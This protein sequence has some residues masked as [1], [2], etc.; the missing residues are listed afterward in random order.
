M[1]SALTAITRDG[2]EAQLHLLIEDARD[3]MEDMMGPIRERSRTYLRWYSPPFDTTLGRHDAWEDAIDYSEDA[4]TTRDNFPIARAV[5]DIWTSLEAAK[6]PMPRAEPEHITP[7][8][9][10][11]DQGEREVRAEQYALERDFESIRSEIRGRIFRDWLR[12]DDFGCYR[13][14]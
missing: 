2:G 4:G 5:V 9:P 13:L 3:S 1:A 12:R 8:L 14:P 6:P 7:P 11:L 10:V